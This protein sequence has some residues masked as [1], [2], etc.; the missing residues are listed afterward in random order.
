M[1][2]LLTAIFLVTALL[3]PMLATAQETPAAETKVAE[4]KSPA[5]EG[6]KEISVDQML[7]KIEGRK[8][9]ILEKLKM[10]FDKLNEKL[11]QIETRVGKA[12]KRIQNQ[13][14]KAGEAK[15]EA[16]G[17]EKPAIN[18]EKLL[19]RKAKATE[20]YNNFKK[21]IETR[22]NEFANRTGENEGNEKG[23]R[24]GEGK[25]MAEHLD[26]L[27]PEDLARVTAARE[28]VRAEIKVEVDKLAAEALLKLEATYQKIMSL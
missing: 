14:Q 9:K 11:A 12:S 20:R 1:K 7:E 19:E 27:S 18:E 16:T 15:V 5:L 22:R 10:R 6:R 8:V 25:G 28:K 21:N 26:K 24:R 17:S 2:K 23:K 13:R 4:A 3:L